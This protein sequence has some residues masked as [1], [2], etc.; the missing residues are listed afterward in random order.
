MEVIKTSGKKNVINWTREMIYTLIELYE[1]HPNLW[2]AASEDYKNRNLR[3]SAVEDI[4]QNM[5]FPVSEI[6]DK[7]HN[8]RC[9]FLENSIKLK[10]GKLLGI[11]LKLNENFTKL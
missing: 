11:I 3:K 4:A 5:D 6:N 9:Q 1:S 2:N 7:I 8:L 10:V